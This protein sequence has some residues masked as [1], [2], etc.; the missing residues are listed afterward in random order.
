MAWHFLTS[1]PRIM[2]VH[3]LLFFEVVCQ[4]YLLFDHL[5]KSTGF[6]DNTGTSP[7]TMAVET[8]SCM[9]HYV[10]PN[11]LLVTFSAPST[12]HAF[13]VS[14]TEALRQAS[15][16][17]GLGQ[18]EE[19]ELVELVLQSYSIG[20]PRS[21]ARHNQTFCLPLVQVSLLPGQPRG[22]HCHF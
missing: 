12:N 9:S 10:I 4:C 18:L 1:I 16:P 8:Q 19:D 11:D 7:I 5:R 20:T 14:Y 21:P 13:K 6:R 17:W 2:I 22:N 3:C 15:L